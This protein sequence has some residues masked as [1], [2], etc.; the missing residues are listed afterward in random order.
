MTTYP[1]SS[2]QLAAEEY[3][4]S[5][6][7]SLRELSGSGGGG[8]RPRPSMSRQRTLM[9]HPNQSSALLFAAPGASA[10]RARRR[11][12]SGGGTGDEA[13]SGAAA[14]AR[15]H[16]FLNDD[17]DALGADSE[18]VNLPDFAH[19]LGFNEGDDPYSIAAGMRSNW[20]R[21]LYLLMEDPGSGREAFFIH[22]AVTGAILFR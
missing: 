5:P 15:R 4:L 13:R 2:S 9:L 22:L 17:L 16:S 12:V 14:T 1:P 20:K 11:T 3:E 10:R 19:I 18:E 21:K 6:T 8:A 7:R